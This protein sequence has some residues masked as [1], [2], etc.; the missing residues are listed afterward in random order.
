MPSSFCS[1]IGKCLQRASGLHV[2]Y[3]EHENDL[4][5]GNWGPDNK[6][7]NWETSTSIRKFEKDEA[8]KYYAGECAIQRWHKF[9]GNEDMVGK[10]TSVKLTPGCQEKGGC[11][12]C[13]SQGLKSI[14]KT[15]C[16][17]GAT[18]AAKKVIKDNLGTILGTLASAV[19]GDLDSQP[20]LDLGGEA[21]ED[22]CAT[23][24]KAIATW[25]KSESPKTCSGSQSCNHVDWAAGNS[26]LWFVDLDKQCSAASQTFL[27][28]PTPSSPTPSSPTPSS[29]SPG[30]QPQTVAA[31][32]YALT[33]T[34][35][36]D[37]C[38]EA[39][40]IVNSGADA[41]VSAL[42]KSTSG[43]TVL[44][45]SLS[46]VGCRRLSNASRRL[47]SQTKGVKADFTVEGQN[48]PQFSVDII[49]NN[50]NTALK[51][52]GLPPVTSVADMKLNKLAANTPV[53][54]SAAMGSTSSLFLLAIFLVG[55]L[56]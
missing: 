56:W 30:P 32:E 10:A 43:V 12:S 31:Q 44:K 51:E 45:T 15:K 9:V 46:E 37:T 55:N 47:T 41:F 16:K 35:T 17:T 36:V 5:L 11:V 49:T 22:A 24:L 34:A 42:M 33:F 29:P 40:R 8:R 52:K 21:M 25:L 54:V 38:L 4:W 53:E 6:C 20:V 13:V 18:K 26:M 23:C 7:K 28:S 2:G 19:S 3:Y 39:S 1:D 50:L 14:V 27:S 48:T